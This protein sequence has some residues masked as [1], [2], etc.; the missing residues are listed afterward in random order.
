MC[1]LAKYEPASKTGMHEWDYK[2]DSGYSALD[3]L[4]R[5]LIELEALEEFINKYNTRFYY[6]IAPL[7][8]GTKI[9]RKRKEIEFLKNNWC[10]MEFLEIQEER[11]EWFESIEDRIT[12][13]YQKELN[14]KSDFAFIE[15]NYWYW[16]NLYIIVTSHEL[17]GNETNIIVSQIASL[18]FSSS[19]LDYL[20]YKN[21]GLINLDMSFFHEEH[22]HLA[23][24]E[25][26]GE[27]ILV[28][29][30]PWKLT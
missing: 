20:I 2:I 1:I 16:N 28:Y 19:L 27:K 26:K 22:S 18:D 30:C 15:E 3:K 17:D 24:R 23:M 13:Y 10:K 8:G 5:Y 25:G 12:F 29:Y 4:N 11:R 9:Q 21:I 6:A 7:N 14:N